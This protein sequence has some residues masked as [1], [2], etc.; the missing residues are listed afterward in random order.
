MSYDT[1]IWE[2]IR[3]LVEHKT[4]ALVQDI[5]VEITKD[6]SLR[7]LQGSY[8]VP[9]QLQ[10]VMRQRAD[11]WVRRMYELC[12]DAYKGVGKEL[13]AEFDRAVWAY[14]LEPFIMRDIQPTASGYRASMLLEL[15]LCAVGSPPERRNQLKVGQKQCCIAVRTRIYDAWYAKLQHVPSKIEQAAAVMARFHAREARAVRIAAGLP[16]EPSPARATVQEVPLS[17]PPQPVQASTLSAVPEAQ[18]PP[19]RPCPEEEQNRDPKRDSPAPSKLAAATTWENIEISFLSDERVQIRAGKKIE[20]R[21]YAELFFEDRRSGKPRQAWETLR[22]LAEQRGLIR[23]PTRAH[24]DWAY[25][26]KRIQDIRKIFR[27]HFG[28]SSDPIPFVEGA[29]YQ[30]R[31]K[32]GCGPSY[33]T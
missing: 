30:A 9:W 12:C 31:F 16:P 18:T 3:D 13:S 25:I 20:T 1:T 27:D 21:N 4:R 24:Q 5:Q 7:E 32:I 2:E 22:T 10:E 28:I 23:Q 15:L 19:A 6:R 8:P 11:S 14:Y 33:R 29:G 17:K 26:E